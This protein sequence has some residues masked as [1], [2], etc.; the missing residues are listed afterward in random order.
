MVIKMDYLFDLHTHSIA[1]GH[2]YSTIH[3]MAYEANKKGLKIL[4]IT[5]HGPAMPG[6]CHEFYFYNLK[7][8]P[9][10][11]CGVELLLGVE[12]NIMDFDGRLDLKEEYLKKMDIVIAS[13]HPPCLKP[14]TK[15]E[16]TQAYINAM[17]NPCVTI[18][19]HPDDG[20]YPVDYEA[21]VLAAK[22][23]HVLLECNN[24][25]LLPDG[26]RA[27]SWKQDEEMLKYCI[28]YQV[29]VVVDS[30]AHYAGHVA[31]VGLMRDRMSKMNFP[32][33]LIINN[34]VEKLRT[35][36]KKK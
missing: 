28:K 17:K 15:D 32:E 27:D 24:G 19:G 25:S 5:E 3:E 10:N 6:T 7:V 22:K 1:S 2:S 4:G 29:P 35:Y 31:E 36:L 33:E 8:V 23:Y 18:I 13:V 9:R 12:A 26:A 34:S 30:D 16:N 21:I 14:G 20:R 11:M